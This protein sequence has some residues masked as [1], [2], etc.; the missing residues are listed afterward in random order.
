VGDALAIIDVTERKVPSEDAYAKERPDL[1]NQ[2]EKGKQYEV[3]ESF[4]K[5]LRQS[6]TVITNDK[7]VDR[8]VGS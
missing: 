2:V 5:A 4:L 3:R 1:T 6:G 8:V 7:S